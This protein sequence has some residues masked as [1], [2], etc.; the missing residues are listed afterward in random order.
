LK[1]R[2]NALGAEPTAEKGTLPIP[3]RRQSLKVMVERLDWLTG[4]FL[5]KR[6][7]YLNPVETRINRNLKKD[8]CANHNY[9][10]ELDLITQLGGISGILVVGPKL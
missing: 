9:G 6:S 5:P 3:E 10:L 2:I 7:P 4:V 8:I 1:E